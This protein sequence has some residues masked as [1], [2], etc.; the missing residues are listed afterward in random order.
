MVQSSRRTFPWAQSSLLWPST[1]TLSS[2]PPA[3]SLILVTTTLFS[4]SVIWS[5]QVY[6][7]NGIVSYVNWGLDL[8][9][10]KFPG[11]SP[12]LLF[13]SIVHSFSD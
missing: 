6:Y 5:F 9:S 1:A 13:L 12:K 2:L 3:P 4:I 7:K 10:A 11:D 8:F